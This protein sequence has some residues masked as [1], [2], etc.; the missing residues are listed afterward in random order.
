MQVKS[1]GTKY[2][3]GDHVGKHSG[4]IGEAGCLSFNGNKIITSGGGGM[5][6][7]NHQKIAEKARYLITQAKDDPVRYIHNEIGYNFRLTNLQAALGVAQLENINK[8][9]ER[10]KLILKAYK[11]ELRAIPGLKIAESP[12]YSKN[13]NWMILLRINKKLFGEDQESK[14]MLRLAESKIQTRPAWSPIHLQKPY[15]KYEN[16]KINNAPTLVDESLCLPSST[17]LSNQGLNI[18]INCLKKFLVYKSGTDL[19]N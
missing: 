13:N 17:N 5:I 16:Y 15:L 3:K 6:L 4:T 8:F 11:K 19:I 18:V 1:L 2:I 14:L 9:I 7:T 10:K 12:K